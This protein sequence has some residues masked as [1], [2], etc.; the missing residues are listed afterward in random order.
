MNFYSLSL[1]SSKKNILSHLKVKDK[2]KQMTLENTL[3]SCR[4]VENKSFPYRC[5]FKNQ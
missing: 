5:N 1:Q 4:S 2:G 3:H